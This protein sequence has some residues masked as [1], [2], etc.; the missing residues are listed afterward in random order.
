MPASKP[1]RFHPQAWQE[2]EAA[3]VWYRQRN[4]EASIRFLSEIYDA[5]ANL[6]QWPE[7][8]PFYQYGTRRFVL[9]RFPFSVIYRDEPAVVSIVAIAHHKRRPGYWKDRT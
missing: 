1:Y 9:H 7:R 6:A 5:L 3:E 2:V 4:Y 8:W